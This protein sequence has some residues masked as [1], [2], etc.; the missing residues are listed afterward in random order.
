MLD[1][2]IAVMDAVGWG[3]A[4]MF[5]ASMGAALVQAMALYH[6][7]RVRTISCAS[8]VPADSSGVKAMRYI[9]FVIFGRLR[10]I[11]PAATREGE[12][13]NLVEMFRIFAH[14]PGYP[15]PE[16]WVRS[17]AE[18][19][20]GRSPRDP[21]STQRQI[22]AGRAQKIPPISGIKVPVLVF[23]GEDDPDHHAQGEQGHRRENPRRRVCHL[24]GHGPQPSRGT[25]A[26]YCQPGRVAGRPR[27]TVGPLSRAS[28]NPRGI[29]AALARVENR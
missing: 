20:H 3:S 22:A 21:K 23:C 16:E 15:F 2:A 18:I 28:A 27:L 1:D 7:E 17:V 9:R 4:H 11:K 10:K 6:P 25:L 13:E 29:W 14:S 26:R 19:S 24:P 8:G 5:G 12:I